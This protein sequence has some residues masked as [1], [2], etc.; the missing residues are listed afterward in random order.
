M[1]THPSPSSPGTAS[2]R[3]HVDKSDTITAE[4]KKFS[5]ARPLAER[6]GVSAKTLFR[7]ADAGLIAR[8][9]INARIVLFDT[10]EVAAYVQSCRVV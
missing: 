6:I 9:K 2:A 8:H 3:K 10:A 1:A 7:W 4:P 5:K